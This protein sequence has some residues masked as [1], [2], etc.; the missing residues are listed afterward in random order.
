MQSAILFFWP[1]ERLPTT[2]PEKKAKKEWKKSLKKAAL[3]FEQ[4]KEFKKL[5]RE[6]EKIEANKEEI[7]NRF[8]TESLNPQDIEELSIKL[9]KLGQELED[10]TERWFELSA[11]RE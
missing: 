4:Q 2:A 3:T 9:G 8:S 11:L 5:E 1:P 7:Q 10:K 6:I